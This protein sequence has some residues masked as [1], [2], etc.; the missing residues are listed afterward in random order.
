[1]WA[2]ALFHAAANLLMD[3]LLKSTFPP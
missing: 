3:L 1:L 2:P